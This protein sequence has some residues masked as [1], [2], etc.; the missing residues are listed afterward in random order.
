MNYGLSKSAKIILSMSMFDV[1][2][3]PNFSKKK[4]SFKNINF[5]AKNIFSYTQFLNHF[6]F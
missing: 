6:V 3:Q 5:F 4:I 2:N 1:K